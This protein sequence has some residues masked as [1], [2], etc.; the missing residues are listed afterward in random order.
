MRYIFE[1]GVTLEWSLS[2]SVAVEVEEV[3]E[4]GTRSS[5]GEET[6][7]FTD[8]THRVMTNLLQPSS[9]FLKNIFVM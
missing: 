4:D 7:Q 8:F 5:I 1:K 2:V 9:V 3:P 6:T